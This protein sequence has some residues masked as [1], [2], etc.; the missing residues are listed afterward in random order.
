MTPIESIQQIL[1]VNADGA[2][3]PLSQAAFD[4]LIHGEPELAPGEHKVKATSFADPA[5][6]AAYRRAIARGA[7]EQ[8]ALAIGDNGVGCWGDDMTSAQPYCALPPEDIIEKFGSM[9]A[10]KHAPVSVTANGRNII[11]RLGDRM[12]ARA[13]ITNGAGIDL[14]PAAVSELGLRPPVSIDAT[15][16]WVG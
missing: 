3:G 7:S 2:W 8:E 10:G 15:W 4:R 11:C 13:H 16:S 5:D 1:G 14:S 9:A 6:I 12:P